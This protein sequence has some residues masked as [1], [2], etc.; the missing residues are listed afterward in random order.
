M[1]EGLGEVLI[2]YTMALP[3]RTGART[4]ILA[5]SHRSDQSVYMVNVLAPGDATI[6]IVD[7]KRDP[8]QSRYELDFRQE[9]VA[10]A[11]DK[12]PISAEQTRWQ[13]LGLARFF[14]LG[15]NHIAEGTDH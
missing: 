10:A 1:R 8:R 5:N 3:K 2:D 14:Q 4:F 11:T 13:G 15:M 6:R 12:A 7:Q 9:A